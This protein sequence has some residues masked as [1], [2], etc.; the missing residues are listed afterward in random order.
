MSKVDSTNKVSNNADNNAKDGEGEF[1]QVRKKSEKNTANHDKNIERKKNKSRSRNNSLGEGRP[2]KPRLDYINFFIFFFQILIS[3]SRNSS[4]NAS[5]VSKVENRGGGSRAHR[6]KN[7]R[8]GGKS[9]RTYEDEEWRTVY[10]GFVERG[11]SSEDLAKVFKDS[12]EIERL[13]L[14]EG[15]AFILFK[16]ESSVALACKLDGTCL[17][18]LNLRVAPRKEKPPEVTGETLLDLD[19]KKFRHEK[20]PRLL[21]DIDEFLQ[22]FNCVGSFSQDKKESNTIII[23]GYLEICPK[24]MNTF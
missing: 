2:S 19:M 18:G 16:E 21:R 12:G 17:N 7:Q 6:N 24:Y 20:H 5:R 14:K 13:T 23:P 11:T 1:I 4:A 9:G 8:K 22:G 3:R 15:F 10:I